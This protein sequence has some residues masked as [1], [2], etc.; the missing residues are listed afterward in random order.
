MTADPAEQTPDAAYK[1]LRFVAVTVTG[2]PA[3]DASSQDDSQSPQGPVG[4]QRYLEKESPKLDGQDRGEKSERQTRA[5]N[6]STT[7]NMV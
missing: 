1:H 7:T 6:N 2:L 5:Q 4:C 3:V